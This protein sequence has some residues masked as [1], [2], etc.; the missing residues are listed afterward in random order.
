M[1]FEQ[2]LKIDRGCDS[3]PSLFQEAFDH[4]KGTWSNVLCGKASA[5]EYVEVAAEVAAVAVGALAIRQASKLIAARFGAA[6]EAAAQMKGSSGSFDPLMETELAFLKEIKEARIANAE[7]LKTLKRSPDG[8]FIV[9]F[10]PGKVSQ[11]Y[12]ASPFSPAPDAYAKVTAAAKGD[13][14]GLSSGKPYLSK[15]ALNPSGT[16]LGNSV[17]SL[18]RDLR[19]KM[20]TDPSAHAAGSALAAAFRRGI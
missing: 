15:V 17:S 9:D 5:S 14:L 6:G 3:S 1:S 8:A 11:G 16:N 13:P 4:V 7:Y 18:D 20:Y 2:S 12:I 10:A 19:K